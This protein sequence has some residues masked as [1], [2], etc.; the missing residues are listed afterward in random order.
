LAAL[1]TS[2]GNSNLRRLEGASGET[3]SGRLRTDF[4]KFRFGGIE[5]DGAN[6]SQYSSV[7]SAVEA[8]HAFTE[9]TEAKK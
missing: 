7:P 1:V 9:V 2:I 6:L 3:L 5:I 8:I 4:G